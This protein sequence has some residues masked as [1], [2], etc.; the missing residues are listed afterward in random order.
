MPSGATF[1][2]G[3]GPSSTAAGTRLEGRPA[4]RPAPPAVFNFASPGHLRVLGRRCGAVAF[5]MA[6]TD[7]LFLLLA[8]GAFLAGEQRRWWLMALLYGLASLTRLQGAR[9]VPKD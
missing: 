6:Y 3:D 1:A 8:A 5:G 4:R 7:S 9:F 2:D